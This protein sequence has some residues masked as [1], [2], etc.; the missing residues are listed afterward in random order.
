M[1]NNNLSFFSDVETL[2]VPR[3]ESSSEEQDTKGKT[4]KIT[5]AKN[6]QVRRL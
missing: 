4:L 5:F 1:K 3:K 6:N 2:N